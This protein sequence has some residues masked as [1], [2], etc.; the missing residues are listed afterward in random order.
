MSTATIAH[1]ICARFCPPYAWP[2]TNGVQSRSARAHRANLARR[3]LYAE[4]RKR[5]LTARQTDALKRAGKW[6][7]ANNHAA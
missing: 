1:W 4:G 7:W 6:D 2:E 5:G 3:H